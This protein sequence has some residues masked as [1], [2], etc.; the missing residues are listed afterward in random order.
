LIREAVADDAG[1]IA[2]VINES[3]CRA[4]RSII[5][6]EY[7]RCPVVTRED[8]L[9]DMRVMRF[10]VYVVDGE[11]V[12]VAALHPKPGEG[13]GVIRWVYV[14]PKHQRRGVGTA[15]VRYVESVARGLGL[16]KLRLVT[17]E[18]AYWA[19]RFYEKLGYRTVAY[20]Q[21]RAWRDVVMEKTIS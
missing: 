8:V 11:V 13:L 3:N 2:R 5:P 21:R 1:D 4:Y 14:D 10:F 18:R 6:P 15:L 7:F 17:H 16:R 9:R 12:G 19:I 20:V